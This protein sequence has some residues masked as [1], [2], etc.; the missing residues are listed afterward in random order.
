MRGVNGSK[1]ASGGDGCGVS[2]EGA[3]RKT[4]GAEP[5][6]V[7]RGTCTAP[8]QTVVLVA[9]RGGDFCWLRGSH[10]QGSARTGVSPD[11]GCE[12]QSSDAQGPSTVLVSSHG[13]LEAPR[14]AQPCQAGSPRAHLQ[15]QASRGH[16]KPSPLGA[17]WDRALWVLLGLPT[18]RDQP[19]PSWDRGALGVHAG[20]ALSCA[21]SS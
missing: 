8:Q 20:C 19:R 14:G 18:S 1:G 6:E 3:R 15:A 10:S 4:G 16:L 21:P 13:H 17:A 2:P 12:P 9:V 7:I 11:M 5:W